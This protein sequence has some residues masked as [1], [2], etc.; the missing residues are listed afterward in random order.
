MTSDPDLKD[1]PLPD[2]DRL[3]RAFSLTERLMGGAPGDADARPEPVKEAGKSLRYWLWRVGG[4]KRPG[5]DARQVAENYERELARL[6]ETLRSQGEKAL[7]RERARVAELERLTDQ[8]QQAYQAE[9]TKLRPAAPDDLE[10]LSARCAEAEDRARLAENKVEMLKEAL[11]ITRARAG[12]GPCGPTDDRF[13]EAKRA[14]ARLFHPDHG[15]RDAPE[16]G[17]VFLEFWPVLERIERGE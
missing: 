8:L 16:R 3:A 1:S 12:S 17:Q 11:E 13:R 5:G 15:G 10:R 6:S 4:R 2:D 9:L 14:F 7:A